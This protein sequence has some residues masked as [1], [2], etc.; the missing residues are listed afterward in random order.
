MSFCFENCITTTSNERA[1]FPDKKFY[2]SP[3]TLI[4]ANLDELSNNSEEEVLIYIKDLQV[5]L[6]ALGRLPTV[7]IITKNLYLT[8]THKL[9]SCFSS[10]VIRDPWTRDFCAN[11][12]IGINIL[13]LH[14]SVH[15]LVAS[16]QKCIQDSDDYKCD[17]FE[18]CFID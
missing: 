10:K 16:V 4:R 5:A 17:H 11:T 8:V 3:D 13:S 2:P 14:L 6:E 18:I 1:L 15:Y 7:R 12:G 9:N